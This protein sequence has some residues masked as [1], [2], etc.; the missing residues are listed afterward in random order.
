MKNNQ[1]V[2]DRFLNKGNNKYYTFLFSLFIFFPFIGTMSLKAIVWMVLPFI[3]QWL[4]LQRRAPCRRALRGLFQGLWK[5]LK[6]EAWGGRLSH[7]PHFFPGTFF[8]LFC[9]FHIV[10]S[11]G[12][13]H[14]VQL[15]ETF[16]HTVLFFLHRS[17]FCTRSLLSNFF[18]G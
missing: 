13:F 16:F 18:P 2:I 14:T 11:V 15:F 12:L 17:T 7:F 1:N 5:P 6:G 4:A 8:T 10:L 3:R 9:S